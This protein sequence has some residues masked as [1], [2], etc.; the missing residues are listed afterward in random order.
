MSLAVPSRSEVKAMRVPSGDQAGSSPP[1]V[2]SGSSL[3]AP[4][5][6]TQISPDFS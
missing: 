3:L 5:F 1:S 2:V 4:S 6:L